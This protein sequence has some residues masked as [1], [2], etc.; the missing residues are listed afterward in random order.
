MAALPADLRAALAAWTIYTDN[1]CDASNSSAT[2]T[3]SVDYLPLLSEFEV[4]GSRTY[5]NEYEK[6]LQTQMSYYANG[7]SKIKYKHGSVGDTCIW[8]V[9]SAHCN[10]SYIFYNVN[11]S[12]FPSY[13]IA[14]TAFGLAP[15]FRVA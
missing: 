1:T 10:F 6:N 9:R 8:W 2:V 11:T 3:A 7:N 12:G 15:A 13:F 14:N 5:A 4:Q